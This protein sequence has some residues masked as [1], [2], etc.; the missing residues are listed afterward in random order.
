MK[1][2]PS[3]PKLPHRTAS[4]SFKQEVLAEWVKGTVSCSIPSGALH[5]L[6]WG[7]ASGSSIMG[8][9]VQPGGQGGVF[10][11]KRQLVRHTSYSGF[12]GKSLGMKH[13]VLPL[14]TSQH[15]GRKCSVHHH[16]ENDNCISYSPVTSIGFSG[17]PCF[18]EKP[19]GTT[20][21]EFINW[22]TVSPLPLMTKRHMTSQIFDS[23]RF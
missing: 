8:T 16:P 23:W 19:A 3:S 17:S 2:P 9:A 15:R 12:E 5:C 6:C 1:N 7:R 4:P 22:R 21:L 14:K 10:L 11:C 20:V 18:A 13:C